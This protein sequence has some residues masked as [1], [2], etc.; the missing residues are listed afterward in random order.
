MANNKT[1][2]SKGLLLTLVTRQIKQLDDNYL[3]KVA[4]L[5][6]TNRAVQLI[7]VS[8]EDEI[9][10]EVFKIISMETIEAVAKD[11]GW[12]I[13]HSRGTDSIPSVVTIRRYNCKNY[14]L[15]D[16][17]THTGK[18]VEK[19]CLHF[20]RKNQFKQQTYVDKSKT[21][22]D[23]LAKEYKTRVA[24]SRRNHGIIK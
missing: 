16:L 19:T 18:I 6:P 23:K 12:F 17:E 3:E 9:D 20:L 2:S 14:H 21:L 4:I 22:S 10:Y 8:F 11:E 7:V 15:R 13:T 5:E 24:T 1:M